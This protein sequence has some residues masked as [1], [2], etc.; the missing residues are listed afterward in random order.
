MQ[1]TPLPTPPRWHRREHETSTLGSVVTLRHF[2]ERVK[3]GARVPE[4][5]DAG[6]H[7]SFRPGH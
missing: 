1:T 4:S 2:E 3:A 7:T 5:R 6:E